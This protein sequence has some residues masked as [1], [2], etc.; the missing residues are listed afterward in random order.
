MTMRPSATVAR[1]DGA[2]AEADA[3]QSS[4]ST[5]GAMSLLPLAMHAQSSDNNL[6]HA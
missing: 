2:V 6:L 5:E 3:R 4:C 1:G